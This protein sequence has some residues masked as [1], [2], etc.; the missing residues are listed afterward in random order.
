MPLGG[1]GHDLMTQPFAETP[2]ELLTGIVGPPNQVVRVRFFHAS[3]GNTQQ[4]SAPEV[5]CHD[6]IA[7]ETNTL[8]RQQSSHEE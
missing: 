3:A 8:A 4:A 1:C 5:V 6:Q 7:D 2:D